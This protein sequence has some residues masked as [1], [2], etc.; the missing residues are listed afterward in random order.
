MSYFNKPKLYDTGF[1]QNYS[2]LRVKQGLFP[3]ELSSDCF[4]S[5]PNFNKSIYCKNCYGY[6]NPQNKY[7][8]LYLAQ[9][10]TQDK[11][12]LP[13][14]NRDL[15]YPIHNDPIN[16]GSMPP[17]MYNCECTRYIQAP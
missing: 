2:D 10:S 16:Y 17:P 11:I 7:N 6:D 12:R 8:A 1:L 14:I 13:L 4:I 5:V 9:Q 15:M 3:Q